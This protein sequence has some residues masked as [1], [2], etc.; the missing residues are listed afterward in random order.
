MDH[1]GI[2]CKVFTS[3]QEVKVVDSVCKVKLKVIAV[4]ISTSVSSVMSQRAP[5][6]HQQLLQGS[7]DTSA[8]Y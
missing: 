5:A 4:I 3:K 7:D 2:N 1:K 8:R 6:P